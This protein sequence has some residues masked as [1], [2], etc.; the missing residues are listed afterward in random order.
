VARNRAR[1]LRSAQ[2]VIITIGPDATI[3]EFADHAEVAVATLYA[4]FGSKDGLVR[5][6]V[7]DGL[8]QWERWMFQAIAPVTGGVEQLVASIRLSMRAP[9]THPDTA[10]L[11][12]RAAQAHLASPD[13]VGRGVGARIDSLVREGLLTG[14][15]MHLRARALV[16]VVTAEIARQ[17]SLPAPE[18]AEADRVLEWALPMLGIPPARARRLAHAPLPALPP[19][20]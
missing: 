6:A 8:E 13:D 16:A 12:T 14:D 18:P 20:G 15:D 1:H 17:V 5:A 10:V 7:Q 11:F 4:H 3:N 19:T 9:V 2:E